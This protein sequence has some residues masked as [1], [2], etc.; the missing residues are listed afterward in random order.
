MLRERIRAYALY[1]VGKPD[2]CEVFAVTERI[3]T[4]ADHTIRY[5]DTL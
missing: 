4:N 3:P 5:I 2:V 1:T